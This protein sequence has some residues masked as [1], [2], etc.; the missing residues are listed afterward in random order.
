MHLSTFGWTSYFE[1]YSASLRE[2]GLQFGRV[3][4]LSR[5]VYNLY[6]ERGEQRAQ[7]SGRLR[8]RA[9]QASEL[10]A[11][12]DWVA[13]REHDGACVIHAVLPRH[14][15]F[16]RKLAGRTTEE[17]VLAANV[18]K[19][20]LLTGLDND[21]NLRRIERYLAIA[22]ESGAMPVV[23]LNKS[24][25]CAEVGGRVVEAEGVALGA[26]VHTISSLTGE[27]LEQ[28]ESEMLPG[29]TVALLGSSGV[30][31]TTLI[32]CL[33][34]K[35]MFATLP[36]RAGDNRGRH[37]TTARSVILLPSGA[38]VMDTPG[39][40]ELQIWESDE[41]LGR[42]FDEIETLAVRCG[43]SDCSHVS[44]PRCAVRAAV[45]DGR[46]APERLE[47]FC[48]LQR[49]IRYLARQQDIAA[50]LAEKRSGRAFTRRCATLTSGSELRAPKLSSHATAHRR[51]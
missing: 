36:V 39:L 3:G 29:Q 18:D 25:L 45:E 4:W 40:R 5:G 38:L 8:H 20:F 34:G 1:Q 49:E 14:S 30:G 24:D 50:H 22:W 32:N 43:F 42:A 31:K 37:T 15:K 11:V 28:L 23:V 12:G 26:A 17:Q 9:A 47:N 27:G 21:Y 48:K 6:T 41:G 7:L 51:R 46:L 2:Q 10:P 19:V 16:S 35:D 44:E 33:V 13:F